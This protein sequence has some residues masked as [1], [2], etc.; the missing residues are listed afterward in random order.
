M[1]TGSPA[2]EEM[3]GRTCP[4]CRFGLERG[5][6][7][8]SC[9]VCDAVHHDDCWE[10]NGGCAVALCAG[11]PTRA[12]A[13]QQATAE[14]EPEPTPE[15]LP[16]VA[17]VRAAPVTAGK[18]A[19]SPPPAG[20]APP[21]QDG[22]PSWSKWIPLIAVAIVLLGGGAAA[23]IVVTGKDHGHNEVAT[24]EVPAETEEFESGQEE[25]EEEEFQRELEEERE[26]EVR[27]E[28]EE[29]SRALS[30]PA[31]RAQRHI[32][33]DL[34]AHFERLEAGEYESAWYDLAPNLRSE[35]EQSGWEREEARA[36]LHN[37][38]LEVEASLYDSSSAEASVAEFVTH[39]E[40]L[41]CRRWSGSWEMSKVEGQWLIS[42][43]NLEKHPC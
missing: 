25:L 28:Q 17:Q 2:T 29:E 26:E 36:G 3:V 21:V 35:Y 43:S 37:F 38:D 39:D 24:V 5:V 19:H 33:H 32:Q 4:Y 34:T 7:V 11:G 31:D 12:E 42:G 16:P 13:P 30:S 6:N 40:L 14:P 9:P 18:E 23:A 15:P 41:G 8:I 1:T 20:G 10:E 22:G 27:R